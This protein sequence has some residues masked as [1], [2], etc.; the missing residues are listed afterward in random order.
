MALPWPFAGAGL[1]F[2]PKP[3]KW[4]KYVKQGFGVMIL[5]FAVY[6]GHLA[7]HAYQSFRPQV[8]AARG[9]ADSAAA[10]DQTDRELMAALQESRTTGRPLFIDFHASWCKDCSAMDATVFNRSDVKSRLQQF[11]VVRYAAEQPNNAPAK[12]LL[13][14]FSIVGL[15]AY[16]VLSSK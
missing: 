15:P 5:A 11:I 2:L 7:W 1:T 14:H 10:P 13:Y 8:A 4:M 3:G 16:L 9:A 6:Y 12:P